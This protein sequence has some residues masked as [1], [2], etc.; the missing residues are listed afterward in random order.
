MSS[1]GENARKFYSKT[2]CFAS[3]KYYTSEIFDAAV[4][5]IQFNSPRISINAARMLHNNML[6]WYEASKSN[7]VC[8]YVWKSAVCTILINRSKI[9]TR[10]IYFVTWKNRVLAGWTLKSDFNRIYWK[11]F[12]EIFN[13]FNHLVWKLKLFL[14]ITIIVK[15]CSIFTNRSM[16]VVCQGDSNDVPFICE[17]FFLLSHLFEDLKHKPIQ[18]KSWQKHRNIDIQCFHMNMLNV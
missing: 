3:T 9:L 7:T 2:F 6:I 15:N 4:K 10:Q 8:I 17:V 1:F 11:I 5:R 16:C 14:L 18:K 13:I 12:I